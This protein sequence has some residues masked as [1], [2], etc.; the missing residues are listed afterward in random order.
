MIKETLKNAIR[1][2]SNRHGIG[3]KEVRIKI[4]KPKD[5]LKYEIMKNSDVLEETNLATALNL[6]T[7]TAFMVG[8]RLNTI[9]DS[10]SK[11]YGVPESSMNVRIY[12]KTDDCEPLLY[13]FEETTPKQALDIDKFI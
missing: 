5:S 10:I 9:V 3:E 2:L 6:N 8:N 4:S 7:I 11:E 13:L 1:S 12:T